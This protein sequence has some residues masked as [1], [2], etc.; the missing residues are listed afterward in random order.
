MCSARAGSMT[1][2]MVGS[3]RE[4]PGGSTS[5]TG[6]IGSSRAT[7]VNASRI[8]SPS[9]RGT[10]RSARELRQRQ[11]EHDGHG[12][13]AGGRPGRDKR[14]GSPRNE[15]RTDRLGMVSWSRPRGLR[16]SAGFYGAAIR[17]RPEEWRSG[18]SVALTW[19][20]AREAARRARVARRSAPSTQSRSP[21]VRGV[22]HPS[23]S[24]RQLYRESRRRARRGC[25]NGLARARS[26]PASTRPSARHTPGRGPRVPRRGAGAVG[27]LAIG[28]T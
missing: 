27:R 20:C 7:L 14:R 11:A 21:G 24:A 5:W 8:G 12:A 26:W 10:C 15:G 17:G 28:R 16:G 19:R 9:A 1:V 4:C 23:A 3:S 2:V 25:P 6:A 18:G 22:R 13:P